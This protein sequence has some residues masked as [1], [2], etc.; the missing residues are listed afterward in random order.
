MQK[1]YRAASPTFTP[2]Q[3][4]QILQSTKSMLQ[5]KYMLSM[6]ENVKA[7]ESSFANYCN[8]AFGIATNSCTNALEIVL[9]AL[10]LS[11]S[12]SVIIPTQTFF[13]NASSVINANANIKLG[14]CDESFLLSYEWLENNLTSEVKAVVIVHFAGSITKD[15]FKIKNLCKQK[16]VFLI[17]D[18]S[19]AHGA[20]A[21]DSKGQEFKAGSIGDVGVFS[22]FSTK[23]LTTGEG[24]MIVCDDKNLALNYRARA[25]RGLDS[26]KSNEEFIVI[27]SNCRMSEFCGIL[28]LSGLQELENNL[29][30]RQKLAKV[31]K[32]QLKNLLD[33]KILRIQQVPKGFRHSYWRFIVFLEIQGIRDKVLDSLKEFRIY[34]D[35]PYKPLLHNQP[36][37]QD[38]KIKL[39][40]T[41]NLANN[42][43]SLP[44]HNGI[45]KKDAK[46]IAKKLKK[47][48]AV[49]IDKKAA[50]V[51]QTAAVM[52]SETKLDSKKA[53]L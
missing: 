28:G 31:Y 53:K 3:Q 44:L 29:T 1:V 23:I 52:L 5:G 19:H 46:F 24:G 41:Q 10:N 35:A 6:G 47:I 8:R 22:F 17:E 14:E 32:K 2:T 37:L 36:L 40:L 27:S 15:I 43:I 4:K 13:A 50:P 34:A 30:H 33:S 51:I 11:K 9:K 45:T 18:C 26:T 42:H 21:L 16:G 25:N 20:V 7:F 12:D 49:I 38:S 48:L 39:P